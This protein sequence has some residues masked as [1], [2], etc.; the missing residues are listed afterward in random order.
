MAQAV[1]RRLPTAAVRVRA[2]VRSCGI[3]GGPSCTGAGSLRVIRFPL[4]ISIPPRA[5]QSSPSIIWGWC[6]RPVL[7]AVPSGLRLT[8]RLH[9]THISSGAA[10]EFADGVR[11]R[12]KTTATVKGKEDT[13]RSSQSCLEREVA[14]ITTWAPSRLR[15]ASARILWTHHHSHHTKRPPTNSVVN[16]W[17]VRPLP[18]NSLQEG[19]RKRSMRETRC[20][21]SERYSGTGKTVRMMTEKQ[22]RGVQER[23]STVGKGA[24]AG[25]NGGSRGT[26]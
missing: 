24:G 22:Q 3:C 20:K 17:K 5:P 10:H 8:P 1:S 6:N 9:R 12:P 4:P 26:H 18:H 21:T 16:R 7:A 2:Q 13:M 14:D 11:K 23:W 25:G 15:E 19:G